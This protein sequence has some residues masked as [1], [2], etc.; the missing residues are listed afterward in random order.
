MLPAL[1]QAAWVCMYARH[2]Q[3]LRFSRMMMNSTLPGS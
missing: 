3:A 2:L 1:L